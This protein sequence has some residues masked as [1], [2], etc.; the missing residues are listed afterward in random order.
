MTIRYTDLQQ[1]LNKARD[2]LKGLNDNIRKIIG[3]DPSTT[4]QYNNG[5]SCFGAYSRNEARKRNLN[6]FEHGRKVEQDRRFDGQNLAK[7]RVVGETKSV[8]SRLSGPPNRDIEYEKPRIHSRVIKEQPTRQEI[9]A[10]QGSDEQS[11]ARNRRIFGSLLGT[12]QKFSQE[13][14]KLKSKEEKKA[15]IEKKLEQ[16]QKTEREN[17]RKQKQSL[18]TGR[19]RQQL[20][21]R[22][23][24]TKMIKMRDFE[25]WEDS[26]KPLAK[27]IKTQTKPQ[28][29]YLPKKL[30]AKMEMKLK[31]SQEEYR[32][33]V[34]KKRQEVLDSIANVEVRFQADIKRLE[35]NANRGNSDANEY[36]L[37]ILKHDQVATADEDDDFHD[38]HPNS[39][40]NEDDHFENVEG[41]ALPSTMAASN[42]KITIQ[43]EI[44]QEKSEAI[45]QVVRLVDESTL[46]LFNDDAPQENIS[47]LAQG[48]SLQITFKTDGEC[49]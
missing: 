18:F 41:P 29:F 44:K 36:N 3:R 48:E 49:E 25:S 27:Y 28:I 15:Q 42:F 32:K 37:M 4:E 45:Q 16:Q 31:D 33:A 5:N 14:S 35:E 23:L 26:K 38:D 12:L 13:E 17:V 6:V 19:K 22:A 1:E 46:S 24:E 9:V 40:Y 8:F 2:N 21:I 10:A 20:E 11:K 43:N 30:D 47:F 7:R 39:P 34:E